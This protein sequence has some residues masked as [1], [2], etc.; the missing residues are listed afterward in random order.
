[1]LA[2][3]APPPTPIEV[4]PQITLPQ[5]APS[6]IGVTG[7]INGAAQR[8]DEALAKV[9]RDNQLVPLNASRDLRF[10]LHEV[11]VKQMTA[12]AYM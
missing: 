3:C 7:S 6:L 10:L 5:Q 4:A 8:Q 2:G 1:M 9:T 12:R 11:L